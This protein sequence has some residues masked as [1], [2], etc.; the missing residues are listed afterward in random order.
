M[1][2]SLSVR[3]LESL[4][5]DEKCPT[6]TFKILVKYL[7]KLYV[8]SHRLRLWAIWDNLLCVFLV[9]HRILLVGWNCLGGAVV[10]ILTESIGGPFR[11]SP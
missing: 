5:K 1:D 3:S 6:Y 4:T 7:A 8:A 9:D 11:V 10:C 2:C